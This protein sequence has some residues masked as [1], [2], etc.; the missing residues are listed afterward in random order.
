MK[1]I[2]KNYLRVLL[3]NIGIFCLIGVS[4]IMADNKSQNIIRFVAYGI[5]C[6]LGITGVMLSKRFKYAIPYMATFVQ[7]LQ[8]LQLMFL[9]QYHVKQVEESQGEESYDFKF[10]IRV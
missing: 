2:N 7:T 8:P 6:L 5:H 4:V 1:F 9:F 10:F 3:L